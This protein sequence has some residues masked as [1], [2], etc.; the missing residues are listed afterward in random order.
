[1]QGVEIAAIETI[2]Q[3]GDFQIVKSLELHVG[4]R[5]GFSQ[6]WLILSQ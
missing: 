4:I 6:L 3:F 5:E 1:M 2:L